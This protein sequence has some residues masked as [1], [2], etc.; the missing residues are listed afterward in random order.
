MTDTPR[1]PVVSAAE[2]ELTRALAAFQACRWSARGSELKAAL[3]AV[4]AARAKLDAA[5]KHRVAA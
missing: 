4:V 2:A 5:R 3:D 1:D